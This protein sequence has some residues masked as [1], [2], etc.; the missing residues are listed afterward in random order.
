MNEA[1]GCA[2]R[3]RDKLN[4]NRL[5]SEDNVPSM[6]ECDRGIAGGSDETC[7]NM[8]NSSVEFVSLTILVRSVEDTVCGV[9]YVLITFD[10]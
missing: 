2:L 4:P 7:S 9:P 1:E 8:A 10:N 6:G 3:L 5:S